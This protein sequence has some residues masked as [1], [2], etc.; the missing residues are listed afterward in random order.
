ME[1]VERTYLVA[2]TSVKPPTAGGAS[3]R[4]ERMTYEV[5]RSSLTEMLRWTPRADRV[6]CTALQ[7]AWVECERAL[8]A[9]PAPPDEQS[10]MGFD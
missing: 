7:L 8:A 1:K 4:P 5:I 2:G 10:R 6:L 9:M 3:Q